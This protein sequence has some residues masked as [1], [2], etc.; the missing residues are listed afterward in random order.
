MIGAAVAAGLWSSLI[1]Y[2]QQD[3]ALKLQI[4]GPN[5]DLAMAFVALTLAPL[6]MST[7]WKKHK[8]GTYLGL[9]SSIPQLVPEGPKRAALEIMSWFN[10]PAYALW[11]AAILGYRR[12]GLIDEYEE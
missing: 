2:Q 7:D 9:F 10:L 11:D 6:V 8:N 12:L 1:W 5:I 4:F 3:W